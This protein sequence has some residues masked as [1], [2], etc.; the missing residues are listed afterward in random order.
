[1]KR[2]SKWSIYDGFKRYVFKTGKYTK[3]NLVYM[4]RKGE[5]FTT[6]F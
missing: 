4:R 6:L 1:M 5:P 2:F 3:E